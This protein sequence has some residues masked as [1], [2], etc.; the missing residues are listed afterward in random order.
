M[1]KLKEEN[2]R[3]GVMQNE[4]N[5]CTFWNIL[6][7]LIKAVETHLPYTH[8]IINSLLLCL[9]QTNSKVVQKWMDGVKSFLLTEKAAQGDAEGLQRQLDQCTVSFVF[10][11][12]LLKSYVYHLFI[13]LLLLLPMMYY[14]K[15]ARIVLSIFRTKF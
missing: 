5:A 7:T 12:N 8:S 13:I 1:E 3:S 9:I 14:V 11:R 4:W 2:N 6:L 15:P 10:L